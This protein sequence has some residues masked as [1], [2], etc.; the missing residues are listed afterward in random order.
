MPFS[1]P[2]TLLRSYI[3]TNHKCS[4]LTVGWST[5]ISSILDV[6]IEGCFTNIVHCTS[7]QHQVQVG[8]QFTILEYLLIKLDRV[9]NT[10]R[11][12]GVYLSRAAASA[13]EQLNTFVSATSWIM[14]V[15]TRGRA[16]RRPA[17]RALSP[18]K[19]RLSRQSHGHGRGRRSACSGPQPAALSL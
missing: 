18:G 8:T 5:S 6:L 2:G 4:L 3:P 17:H 1:L 19:A 14:V 7:Q 9:R 15:S 16:L 11:T 12:A 13:A 10:I